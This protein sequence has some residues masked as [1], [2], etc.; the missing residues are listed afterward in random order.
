MAF[1]LWLIRKVVSYASIIYVILL[2]TVVC[3]IGSTDLPPNSLDAL[4]KVST[5]VDKKT[6]QCLERFKS[7]PFTR[8]IDDVFMLIEFVVVILFTHL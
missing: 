3:T 6:P 5:V 4:F 8:L 7:Y 2:V 1:V